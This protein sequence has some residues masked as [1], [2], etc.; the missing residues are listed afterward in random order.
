MLD[1]SPKP[2]TLQV[3]EIIRTAQCGFYKNTPK[4]CC[5]LQYQTS[6]TETS[7]T[8]TPSTT[9]SIAENRET[10]AFNLPKV[11]LRIHPNYS[12]L[13]N[14]ICG[15]IPTNNRITGGSKTSM[16]EFPWMALLA[17]NTSKNFQ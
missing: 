5:Y 10:Q 1:R 6:T 15:E 12:L 4:V 3:I 8:I 11:D 16:N 13:P 9:L 14:D 2:R 7:T 17:F